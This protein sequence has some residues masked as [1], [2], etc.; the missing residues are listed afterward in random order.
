MEGWKTNA[1]SPSAP[2]RAPITQNFRAGTQTFDRIVIGVII[3][4]LGALG[5]LEG[6]DRRRGSAFGNCHVSE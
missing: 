4:T 3:V 6:G 2:A 5:A 1:V